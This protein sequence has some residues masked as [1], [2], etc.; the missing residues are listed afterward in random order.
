M[1]YFLWPPE[2][3][4][5]NFIVDYSDKKGHDGKVKFLVSYRLTF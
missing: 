3:C 4:E 1:V 5:N 2:N